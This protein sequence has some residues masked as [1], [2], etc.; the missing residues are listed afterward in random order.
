MFPDDPAWENINFPMLCHPCPHSRQ[1]CPLGALSKRPQFKRA[2][3]PPQPSR[4]S[5]HGASLRLAVPVWCP[6]KH[7][8]PPFC[9]APRTQIDYPVAVL[10]ELLVMFC[11]YYGISGICYAVQEFQEVFDVDWM[12]AGCGLILSLIHI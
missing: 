6:H 11:D 4:P 3:T 1:Y 10:D 2:Y 9:A 12:Q 5:W 8:P 7:N